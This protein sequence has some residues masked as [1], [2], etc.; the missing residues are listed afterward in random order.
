[1]DDVD[2][3]NESLELLEKLKA[4]SRGYVYEKKSLSNCI[5]CDAFIP[6][7][8]RKAIYGCETCIDCAEMSEL[9]AKKYY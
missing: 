6:E 8:R 4:A 2:K 1:M 3:L 9:S 7:E 5:Y